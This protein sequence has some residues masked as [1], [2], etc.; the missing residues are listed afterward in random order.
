LEP[1]VLERTIE[2]GV[3]CSRGAGLSW[4]ESDSR[5]DI[6]DRMSGIEV[7]VTVVARVANAC[8]I[9]QSASGHLLPLEAPREVADRIRE[10]ALQEAVRGST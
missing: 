4:L 5:K 10:V 3:R 7:S 2:D 9:V 1:Q 8:L 6:S